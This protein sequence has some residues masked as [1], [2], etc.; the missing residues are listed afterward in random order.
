MK[1]FEK[2]SLRLVIFLLTAM[3]TLW[4]CSYSTNPFFDIEGTDE[5]IYRIISYEW[6]KGGIPYVDS[7]D[8]KGPWLYTFY[9]LGMSIGSGTLGIL[10]LQLLFLTVDFELLWR[11]GKLLSPSSNVP[12]VTGLII[13]IYIFVQ[14]TGG[15]ALT[16]EWSLPF[17]ILPLYL[18]SRDILKAKGHPLS[19]AFVYGICFGI[20]SLVRINNAATNVGCVLGL[21]TLI[22]LER[23]WRSLLMNGIVALSGIAIATLPFIIYF[24]IHDALDDMIYC[25]Y[26][27]NFSYITKWTGVSDSP[28]SYRLTMNTLRSLPYLLIIPIA[29]LTFF[30]KKSSRSALYLV[31]AL[32]AALQYAT[33]ATGT[34]FE[35]YFITPLPLCFLSIVMILHINNLWLSIAALLIPLICYTRPSHLGNLLTRSANLQYV[36]PSQSITDQAYHL[37][38]TYIPPQQWDDIYPVNLVQANKVYMRLNTVPAGKYNFFI[39]LG[40]KIE[41]RVEDELKTEMESSR[42][43]WLLIDRGI[44][45]DFPNLAP[46]LKNYTPVDSTATLVLYRHID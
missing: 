21:A 17:I 36:V 12:V 24:A 37:V 40:V 8:N 33:L 3:M 43:K 44:S 38:T 9:V 41:R 31:F 25:V 39:N 16:E 19:Y 5:L 29:L 32:A 1:P 23:N 46:M 18:T 20:I 14:F 6:M 7:F 10:I 30:R 45:P 42:F 28:L 2:T 4:L 11:I 35:H 26:T 15:G 13:F 22:I 27:F 34:H